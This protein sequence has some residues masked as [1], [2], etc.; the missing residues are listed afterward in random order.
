M[1][2]SDDGNM[3][4]NASQQTRSNRSM[5]RGGSN[6]DNRNDLL[7]DILFFFFKFIIC[8]NLDLG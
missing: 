4:S 1:Q 3:M 8:R 2:Q 6:F 7:R 5:D